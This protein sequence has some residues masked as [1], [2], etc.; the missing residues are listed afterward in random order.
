[1]RT[2]GSNRSQGCPPQNGLPRLC[3][4]LTS[5]RETAPAVLDR[6]H[7]RKP[8]EVVDA[9]GKIRDRLR[10]LSE[11][12]RRMPKRNK[13]PTG[14]VSLSARKRADTPGPARP[15]P[16]VERFGAFAKHESQL[17]RFLRRTAGPNL[18]I[19]GR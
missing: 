14:M 17:P 2:R 3:R 7:F 1:P 12:S 5:S 18:V 13:V 6:T 11:K 10:L 16:Y 19:A 8:P 4:R 9:P 15:E